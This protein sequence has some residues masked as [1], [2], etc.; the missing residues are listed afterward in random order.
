MAFAHDI[1]DHF[2]CGV[3]HT[4]LY[5]YLCVG[6]IT[7]PTNIM[8]TLYSQK[9]FVTCSTAWR[10]YP[11]IGKVGCFPPEQ[12]RQSLTKAR[13]WMTVFEPASWMR[14][15]SGTKAWSGTTTKLP[16]AACCM[17]SSLAARPHSFGSLSWF[18]CCPTPF[19]DVLSTEVLLRC[20]SVWVAGVVC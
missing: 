6:L 17:M 19:V 16:P 15:H 1:S 13:R 11:C 2:L 4:F 10:F 14:S 9:S 18:W 12:G 5:M 3:D 20:T 7:L 8:L